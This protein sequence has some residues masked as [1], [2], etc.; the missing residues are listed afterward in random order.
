[1]SELFLL[2][3]EK[4]SNYKERVCS[5]QSRPFLDVNWWTRIQKG[6]YTKLSPLSKLVE[7]V[8]SFFIHLYFNRFSQNGT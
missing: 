5:F 2:P 6:I 7:T 1:M 4:G 8:T 3:V